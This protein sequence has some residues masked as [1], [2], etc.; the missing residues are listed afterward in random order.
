MVIVGTMSYP[1]EGAN[2]IGKR[3]M[4]SK[5]IP[6]HITMK[7]PYINS[8]KGAGIQALTVYE[9]DKSKLAEAVELVGTRY[10]DYIGVPGFTYSIQVWFEAVEALKMIGLAK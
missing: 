2:E 9:C 8:L 3:F 7:G 4:A 1:S 6:S 5:P 10:A